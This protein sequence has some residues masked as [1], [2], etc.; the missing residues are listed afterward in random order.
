MNSF[1]R[2]DHFSCYPLYSPSLLLFLL[3]Y[4]LQ[5]I[6]LLFVSSYFLLSFFFS[7]IP[8]LLFSSLSLSS[9]RSFFSLLF[10]SSLLSLFPLSL[11]LFFS[12][13]PS[14]LLL[15]LSSLLSI[16]SIHLSLLSPPPSYS[17]CLPSPLSLSLLPHLPIPIPQ[18]PAFF[19][20]PTSLSLFSL[21]FLSI[22]LFLVI[23]PSS[24]FPLPCLCSLSL[25]SPLSF[26]LGPDV[27]SPSFPPFFLLAFSRFSLSL[28]SLPLLLPPSLLF[29]F[30]FPLSSFP[31]PDSL[32]LKISFPILSLSLFSPSPSLS[33]SPSLFFPPSL[34][35]CPGSLP[36]LR[37]NLTPSLSL[38]LS[39]SSLLL[40]P[41]PSL[42]SSIPLPSP[43]YLPSL[44]SL[45]LLVSP[46]PSCKQS[47]KLN[48]RF[49]D[50]AEG[51]PR[52]DNIQ[53][54]ICFLLL[55]F[56]Y[57]LTISFFLSNA[58]ALFC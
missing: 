10:L 39:I 24:L 27:F 2:I 33:L 58:V 34:F 16:H 26:V 20:S 45:S 31:S 25:A 28:P 14:L 57:Y 46:S 18:F 51:S 3:L 21:F 54:N 36:I 30:F 50:N 12:F 17:P 32:S 11:F 47:S 44:H 22:L 49:Y 15:S 35:V 56:C 29:F 4:F 5:L 9:S 6:T 48:A 38:S 1:D 7:F 55:L 53:N 8:S 41:F 43:P 23:S 13:S 37:P 19:L 52:G 42:S 40:P